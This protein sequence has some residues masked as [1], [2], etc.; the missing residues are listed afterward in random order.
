MEYG[1]RI[2][3][4]PIGIELDVSRDLHGVLN[5][6]FLAQHHPPGRAEAARGEQHHALVG[7]FGRR[8]ELAREHARS[9]GEQLVGHADRAADVLQIGHLRLLADRVD[10]VVQLAQFDELV[11]REHAV[12]LGQLARGLD[13]PNAGREVQHRRYAPEGVQGEERDDRARA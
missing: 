3:H 1:Q 5:E 4:H 12:D 7:G 11:S 2:E 6:I 13:V 9:R 8:A 10:D